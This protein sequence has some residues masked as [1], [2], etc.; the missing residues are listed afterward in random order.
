MFRTMYRIRVNG[1]NTFKI[2]TSV[3]GLYWSDYRIARPTMIAGL[4]EQSTSTF[5]A[6]G[7]AEAAMIRLR[8]QD[9]RRRKAKRW[10]TV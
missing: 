2:Q 8:H 7:D 3:L 9:Q 6:R 10:K 1:L 5:C 4:W